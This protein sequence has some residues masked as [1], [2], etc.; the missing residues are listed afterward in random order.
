MTE[1]ELIDLYW[2]RSER[3]LSETEKSYGSYCRG[4]AY[5]LLRSRED[6]EE[7]VNDTWLAA[8]NAMPPQRPNHLR[9]FLGKM[10][11]NIAISRLRRR[12]SKKRGG[13]ELVLALEELSECLPG[14]G[15]PEQIVEAQ[16]LAACLNAFLETLSRRD[17]SLLL[18]RYFYGFTEAELAKRL[19]MKQSGVHTIL[20]RSRERLREFLK[21]EGIRDE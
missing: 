6:A 13:G 8:W 14:G 5:H 9:V 17:R 7:S 3:A 10:T 11:R 12:E 20:Y 21:K 1:Q 16:E 18:G 15:D 2:K 4:I 19:D